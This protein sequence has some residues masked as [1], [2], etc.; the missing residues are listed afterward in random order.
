MFPYSRKSAQNYEIIPIFAT[1][2]RKFLRMK[3]L[4]IIVFTFLMTILPAFAQED[5]NLSADSILGEYEV[6]HQD[7]YARVRISRE[8]DS[9]YMAQVFWIDDMY[10]KRGMVRL[11]EKNPDRSLREVPCNQIV[12][13][14]GLKYDAQK[15]RW[16][17]T[18]LYDPTRGVRANVT[19]EFREEKGLRVRISFL[20]F[21]QTSWWK[22]LN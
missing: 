10:D 2:H 11:D 18:K 1:A 17:D 7:E 8:T 16:G 20:C 14:T 6:L 12:L 22:K 3:S 5:P 21:A 19:C 9:T 15:Q 4:I 13:M